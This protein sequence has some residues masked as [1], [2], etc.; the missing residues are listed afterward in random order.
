MARSMEPMQQDVGTRRPKQHMYSSRTQIGTAVGRSG[1]S[2][3]NPYMRSG[4]LAAPKPWRAEEQLRASMNPFLDQMEYQ[5][6]RK[7]LVRVCTD[8]VGV[9][10]SLI[11]I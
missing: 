11:H 3:A 4:R 6:M 8:A 1:I 5:G 2:N 7:I 9:A 10:L